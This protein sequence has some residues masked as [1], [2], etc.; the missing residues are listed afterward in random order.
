ME[1][2]RYLR[3]ER[4][5][6]NGYAPI[7]LK[8]TFGKQLYISTGERCLPE[9]WDEEAQKMKGKAPFAHHINSK[10][11]RW[12]EILHDIY[13]EH[14]KRQEL[15]TPTKLKTQF[16]E[17][18]KL[19]KEPEEPVLAPQQ[20]L[21]EEEQSQFFRLFNQ[22]ND[23]LK[24]KIQDHSGKKTSPGTIKG[25]SST[26][27]RFK[28]FEKHRE[29]LITFEGIDKAFYVEF[30]KYM[31]ETLKQKPNNFGKHVKKLKSFL[32]W[33]EEELEEDLQIN[34]KYRGFKVTS[35]YVGVDAL[36]AREVQAIYK[37]DF[38]SQK[39]SDFILE[40]F[41]KARYQDKARVAGYAKELEV[42]RD[43][44]LMMCYTGLRVSDVKKLRPTDI[45]GDVIVL[46]AT[47][48]LNT[49]YIPVYDD[50]VF[51]PNEILDR[52]N[53]LQETCL[54]QIPDPVINRQLKHIQELASISRLN[55][56][57]KI[58]RKTFV[59]LKI[60][61]G[62]ETRLI[63]QAT[64]HKTEAAFNAYVGTDTNELVLAFRRQSAKLDQRPDLKNGHQIGHQF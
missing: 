4:L 61:Q 34:R 59:T 8:I 37:L 6:R 26:I 17:R 42:V 18:V 44:F 63:M 43:I 39:V 45:K 50:V 46:A 56:T 49:C 1:V 11:N 36:S 16:E 41:P 31:L 13:Q 47:K 64:G 60:Y 23:H 3:K 20:E 25:N 27:A 22:W 32:K 35:M 28:E 15:L 52:Y 57:T 5:T 48:T 24:D 19:E 21:V 33:C 10:L 54:P 58:G 2:K 14:E 55:L 30:Q 40:K 7:R 12:E 51:K 53:G 29:R 62:V 38:S 9:H